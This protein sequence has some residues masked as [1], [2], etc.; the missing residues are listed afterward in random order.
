L[1][2]SSGSSSSSSHDGGGD[3]T[4]LY[5]GGVTMQYSLSVDLA[6]TWL[7]WPVSSRGPS[8][9]L[10]QQQQQQQ[11]TRRSKKHGLCQHKQP[12]CRFL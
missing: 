11:R 5:S 8:Q 6:T 10:W 1:G 4:R 3:V 2:S 7:L 12:L 9:H